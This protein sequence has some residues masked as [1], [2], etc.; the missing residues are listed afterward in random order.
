M[1]NNVI[2]ARFMG[3]PACYVAAQTAKHTWS[4]E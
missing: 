1:Y 4:P 2:F 3:L